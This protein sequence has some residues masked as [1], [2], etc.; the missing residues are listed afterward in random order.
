MRRRQRNSKCNPFF[1]ACVYVINKFSLEAILEKKRRATCADVPDGFKATNWMPTMI[2][3]AGCCHNRRPVLIYNDIIWK[4]ITMAAGLSSS[5]EDNMPMPGLNETDFRSGR[6]AWS[7]FLRWSTFGK[8][9][10]LL[11]ISVIVKRMGEREPRKPIHH[12]LVIVF[13]CPYLSI[14]GWCSWCGQK[15]FP[16]M[17]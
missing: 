12:Q 11:L 15:L 7:F 8:L 16:D 17:E 4:L 13:S 2:W 10:S 6:G 14:G 9:E 1:V 3:G 5:I